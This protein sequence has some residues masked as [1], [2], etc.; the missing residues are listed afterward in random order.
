MCR[1]AMSGPYKEHYA[2]FGCRK[3]FRRPSAR[4]LAHPPS[5]GEAPVAPCPQ[6]TLPMVNLGLDFKAP[7][8]GDREQWKALAA[9]YAHGYTFH[10]CGCAGPGPRPQRLREVEP[11]VREQERLRAE[12]ARERRLAAEEA[13]RQ[14]RR[15]KSAED[16]ANQMK[17]AT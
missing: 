9:L 5:E 14:L 10:S 11:F 8:Q 6:C 4:E 1:Y 13:E 17:L 3:M 7:R 12:E 15:R 2:C 16:K